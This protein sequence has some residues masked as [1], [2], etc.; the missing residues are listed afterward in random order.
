M[1]ENLEDQGLDRKHILKNIYIYRRNIVQR[2]I[3][4]WCVSQIGLMYRY[5]CIGVSLGLDFYISLIG[6][7]CLSDWISVSLR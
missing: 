1:R 5:D 4:D 6:F 7:V 2:S 3:M